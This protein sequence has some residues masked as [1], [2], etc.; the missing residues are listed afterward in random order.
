M[1]LVAISSESITIDATAGGVGFTVAKITGKVI[2]AS[3]QVET[4][5]IRIQT[6]SSTITAGGTEGSPT[7]DVGDSFYIYGNPDLLSFKA[8][9]TGGASGTLQVI[10][11]GEGGS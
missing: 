4:A 9:R 8:I 2:R 11:E 1:A 5:Q 6:S 3:C 10:Y 7:R